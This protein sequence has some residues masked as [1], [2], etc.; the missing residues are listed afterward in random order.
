MDWGILLSKETISIL[1]TKEGF[2]MISLSWKLD[3]NSPRT[4]IGGTIGNIVPLVRNLKLTIVSV[5]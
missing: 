3:T 2:E 4:N 1:F 5:H